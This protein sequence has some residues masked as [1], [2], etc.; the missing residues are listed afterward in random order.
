VS[1]PLTSD[2]P[3]CSQFWWINQIQI[4]ILFCVF[5]CY[6]V[7]I[8]VFVSNGVCSVSD[9]SGLVFSFLQLLQKCFFPQC[10]HI[11]C[12]KMPVHW[13]WWCMHYRLSQRNHK[14]NV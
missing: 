11:C 2:L 12:Y 10:W 5:T 9:Y 3:M 4:Q 6:I 14:K 7:F 1:V 13:T 8:N